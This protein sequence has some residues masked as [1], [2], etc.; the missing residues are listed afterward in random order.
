MQQGGLRHLHSRKHPNGK[1]STSPYPHPVK[2]KRA[3]DTF[4]YVIAV[5][6]PLSYVPQVYKLYS[7][8]S[9]EGLAIS[10]FALLFVIN[11]LW[12]LYGWAH[13]SMPLIITSVIFCAF[14][15]I[16]VGGILLYQ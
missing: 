11:A 1:G 12:L 15:V 5:V 7:S 13:R 14:H 8:E 9:A 6:A 2:W 16:I 10:S 3:L 4:M